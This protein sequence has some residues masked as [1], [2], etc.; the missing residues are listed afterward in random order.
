MTNSTHIIWFKRDLRVSDHAPL[1]AAVK[2]GRVLP[3][4][5]IEPE[6]WKLPDSGRRHW[7]FIHDSLVDLQRDLAALGASLVIRIGEATEILEQL[8]HELGAF[9]LWSHEETGNGWTYKRDIAVAQ[10]CH[11]HSIVWHELPSNGVVRR[12]KS[13]DGWAKL[14]DERMSASN[15]PNACHAGIVC[16]LPF[17]ARLA[18]DRAIP[19]AAFYRLRARYSLFPVSDAVGRNRH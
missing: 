8:R 11:A 15:L 5:I 9:T 10:C 4:Y 19:C 14:R 16:K 18:S 6:L 7:H 2:A 1:A 12:L 13:L 3:L 17:M